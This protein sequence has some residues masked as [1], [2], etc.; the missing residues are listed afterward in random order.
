MKLDLKGQFK[1]VQASFFLASLIFC[2]PLQILY[3][4]PR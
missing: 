2:Q 3:V 1:E 4:Y